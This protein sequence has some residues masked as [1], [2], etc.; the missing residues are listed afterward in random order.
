MQQYVVGNWKMNGTRV[1]ASR[2]AAGLA[3]KL[4]D[5]SRPLPKIVICPSSPYI[6]LVH[7]LVVNTT[8]QVGAQNC[9]QHLEGPYTG[10]IS[11]H[12][13]HDMGANY[14]ILG[15]SERRIHFKETNADI[16]AK[17]AMAL[18]KKLIPIICIGETK[19]QKEAGQTAGIILSQLQ[20]SLPKDIPAEKFIIAYEPVWAIGSGSFPSSEE[21]KLI[22]GIIRQELSK[23]VSPGGIVPILYGGSV[24]KN[25]AKEIMKISNVNGV[26]VG[27]AS[28]KLDE[29]WDIIQSSED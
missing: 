10:E 11:A 12:Q 2:I 18:K 1:E 24:S 23:M 16:K 9:S 19:A 5:F 8:I 17:A 21:I 4:S 20:E 14:V 29:F 15:H 28:L 6:N 7:D 22:H 13:A 26:L 25:N 3:K 27:G